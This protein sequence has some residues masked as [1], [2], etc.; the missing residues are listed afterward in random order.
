MQAIDQV[1]K[2]EKKKVDQKIIDKIDRLRQKSDFTLNSILDSMEYSL[3]AGGK[4]IRPIITVKVAE[5]FKGNLKAAY[6]LGLALEFIHSYSLIHD[7]LPAM[8]DD[9]YRRGQL[10]NHKV[11]GE[12][13]AVLTGDA[14]LT[15]AFR[16]LASLNLEPTKIVKIIKLV[17][18]KAGFL[19]MVGGQ[20][21]DIR[22]EDQKIDLDTLMKIHQFKTGALFKAAVLGGAY[23]ASI[24]QEQEEALDNYAE[25][26][27]L[28]FQITDDILDKTGNYDKMGKPIGSDEELNK[29]TYVSILGLAKAREKAVKTADK[30][31][32]A[33]KIFKEAEF[34][35]SLIN[36]ILNRDS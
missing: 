34:L 19:G 10:S 12:G 35:T 1:I 23:C 5:M 21:L 18:D 16:Q 15:F 14:L 9:N 25:K 33:L 4:R 11:F 2:T 20:S 3:S 17:A 27:G 36:Y 29:S 13:M 32:K 7:D 22:Y 30:A 26:L 8:D 28:L 24:D 31:R 6:D